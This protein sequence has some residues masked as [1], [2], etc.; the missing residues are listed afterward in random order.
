MRTD[1]CTRRAT[2]SAY[3]R[4]RVT[5][6]LLSGWWP[7]RNH[8]RPVRLGGHSCMRRWAC[9]RSSCRRMLMPLWTTRSSTSSGQTRVA[10]ATLKSGDKWQAKVYVGP[11]R[12]F[13]ISRLVGGPALLRLREGG[14]KRKQ[15][16]R[17]GPRAPDLQAAP[18]RGP[19]RESWRILENLGESLRT[20]HVGPHALWT[21]CMVWTTDGLRGQFSKKLLILG[22][23]ISKFCRNF[24][25]FGLRRM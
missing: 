15:E 6:R 17:G 19:Q 3:R 10:T 23:Q 16:N 1:I 11:G 18:R 12:A 22:L 8:G 24:G 4:Y 25:S 14:R 21:T 2:H 7:C 9:Q 5:S 20:M 13:L